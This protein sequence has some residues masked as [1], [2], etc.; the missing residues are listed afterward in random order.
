MGRNGSAT[1]EFQTSPRTFPFN[2]TS[3]PQWCSVTSVLSRAEDRARR[4][5][6]AV[7]LI[8]CGVY[9]LALLHRSSLGV[10]GPDAVERLNI[11]AA[12]LGAFVMLQLGVYAA[13]QVPSGLAIDRFGP[14]KVLLVAT[15]T[16]GTAQILFAFAESYPLAL[17]ARALL[18]M[19]DSAVYLAVLRLAAGWFPKRRYAVLAMISGLFGMA[20][21]LAA[22]LPLTLALANF[23]WVQTFAVTGA[24]SLAYSLLLLRPAVAAR[25]GNP[26][27]RSPPGLAGRAESCTTSRRHGAAV[28]SGEEPNSDSGRIRPP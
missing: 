16:M 26:C 2:L 27:P 15:L 6:Y 13:M 23:G 14:R 21:N 12:Q 17:A 8:G 10:A 9:F 4:S 7:W 25:T 18:G 22:T 1:R 20:G 3:G 28:S 19:G 5:P 11:S 24:T